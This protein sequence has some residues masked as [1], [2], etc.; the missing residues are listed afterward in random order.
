MQGGAATEWDLWDLAPLVDLAAPIADHAAPKAPGPRR[1]VE[2]SLPRIDLAERITDRPF[3]HDLMMD[4]M[5][6]ARPTHPPSLSARLVALDMDALRARPG[7]V[8]AVRD[9]S[10]VGVVAS[11][12]PSAAA[13]ARWAH[14][15]AEQADDA[16]ATS[17]STEAEGVAHRIGDAAHPSATEGR[18][19]A[20][21][22]TQPDLAHGSIGPSAAVARR[23][24]GAAEWW[25]SGRTP[26]A[27][28]PCARR[29]RWYSAWTKSRSPSPTVPA[30]AAMAKTAPMTWR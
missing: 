6:H 19:L 29:W 22:V 21:T 1:V 3:V 30:R 4:G 13:A 12:E 17:A 23:E 16:T 27:P 10:F 20:A 2:R 28:I 11:D 7:V 8:A 18:V 5:L 9:G 14:A 15:R 25:R 24:G 26:K